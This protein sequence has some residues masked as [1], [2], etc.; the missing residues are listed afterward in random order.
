MRLFEELR[1]KSA[2]G[3]ARMQDIWEQAFFF[4]ALRCGRLKFQKTGSCS[5]AGHD[6]IP[7]PSVGPRL[8]SGN[9]Q[10]KEDVG[11]GDLKTE[12]NMC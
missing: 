4:L 1:K 11:L 10:G 9:P 5:V 8:K 6:P 2:E 12:R 7:A 3:Q